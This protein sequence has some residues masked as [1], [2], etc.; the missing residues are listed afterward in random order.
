MKFPTSLRRL[1]LPCLLG[2]AALAASL[3]SACNSSTGPSPSTGTGAARLTKLLY[4]PKWYRSFDSTSSIDPNDGALLFA[5][6]FSDSTSHP[7]SFYVGIDT[8]WALPADIG[9]DTANDCDLQVCING[10][11]MNGV[12]D[13]V[14][15]AN[16]P[17][18]F[19]SPDDPGFSAE[20]HFQFIP[21]IQNGT[22]FTAPVGS[23]FGGMMY[24]RSRSGSSR[25]DTV[26]G[27]GA[28]KTQWDSAFPPPVRP[29]SGYL[30]KRTDFKIVNGKVRYQ[31]D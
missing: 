14:F 27:F 23:I 1:R 16:D 11:C 17:Y 12:E 31:P 5:W 26:F 20:Y 24:V 15:G 18:P 29:V 19:G 10:I 4:N 2:G 8:L 7:D 22:T 25:T 9:G 13:R 28:W 6:E 30:P 21:A 3:L